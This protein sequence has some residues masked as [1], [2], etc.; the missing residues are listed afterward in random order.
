MVFDLKNFDYYREGNR[1]EVKKAKGGL[2][3]SLWDTYSS[4]ANCYGGVILLG[5]VE[6]EDGSFS[7]TGL[8]NI[9]KLKKDFWNGINDRK[10]VSLNLL[11]DDDIKTYEIHGDVVLAIHIPRARREDRPV[12]I[13]DDLFGG[14]FRRNGEGDYHCTASEVRAMLRD[15]TE[16]TADMKVLDDMEISDL[17]METVHAYRSRHMAVK[18]DHVWSKLTDEAYLEQIGAVRRSR[19]DKK[20]HPTGAGL[21]MF[22]EEYKILYEY[23]EYFLDYREVLDPTI[24]WT[25]RLQSSSGDWTGNLFDFFFRVY[26]K[27]ARDV[28]VPF[29]LEGITRTEDTPVHKALREALANCLANTDFFLPRG[30]VIRKDMEKITLENPGYIRTGKEQMLRGGISDPRNKALMKLF[31]II[32]IGERAGSGVPDIFAVWESQGWALPEVQ[33]QYNPD[34]TTLTLPFVTACCEPINEPINE[35]IT[36]PLEQRILEQLDANAALSQPALAKKLGV[37]LSTIK[38]TMKALTKAGYVHH[39]G[40]KKAGRWIVLKR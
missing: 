13:N 1:L 14:T 40:S 22:G 34:R 38:R 11:T 12:Y 39:E 17:N 30:I 36:A 35:P 29:K 27:L 33:E 18:P 28:K 19:V 5:V 8:Q 20:L 21:L 16:A 4:M 2:P 26:H 9:E 7:T 25:D 10:K 3:K 37:S 31:N 24:R 6:R 32:G 23:P 15:Q